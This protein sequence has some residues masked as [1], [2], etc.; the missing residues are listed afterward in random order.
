[1]S[2][3]AARTATAPVGFERGLDSALGGSSGWGRTGASS[4]LLRASLLHASRPILISSESATA[5]TASFG[6]LG[7]GNRSVLVSLA[8]GYRLGRY[9]L[10]ERLGQGCQ[11]EVWKAIQIAPFY[12]QVALKLLPPTRA[13]DPKRLAQFRR[14]AERGARL[15]SPSLLP[16][17][18]YGELEG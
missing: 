16:I 5:V 9:I 11:G 7:S 6:S 1:G 4:T 12:D 18:E 13:L 17:Y 10:V 14:E 15:A 8:P 2:L 3:I